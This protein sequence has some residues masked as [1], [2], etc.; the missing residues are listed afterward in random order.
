ME[1]ILKQIESA[2]AWC[3]EGCAVDIKETAEYKQ[4]KTELENDKQH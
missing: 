4:I 1:E 2:L 3:Y